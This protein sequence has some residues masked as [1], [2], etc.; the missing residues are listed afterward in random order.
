M[1]R[2]P[3]QK[4]ELVFTASPETNRRAPFAASGLIT[5]C[6]LSRARPRHLCLPL[7]IDSHG[8]RLSGSIGGLVVRTHASRFCESRNHQPPWTE[9]TK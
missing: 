9:P 1:R 5:H 8:G 7:T 3:S 4:I 6:A 2:L